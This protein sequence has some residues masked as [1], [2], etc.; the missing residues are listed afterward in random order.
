MARAEASGNNDLV[1]SQDFYALSDFRDLI[2][3]ESEQQMTL[4]DIEA[5]LDKESLAFAGFSLDATTLERFGRA[6]PDDPLPGRLANWAAFERDNPQTFE[7]M[8]CFWCRKND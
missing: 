7:A 5:F 1:R 2:L 8:Y 4:E 6:F 3:H